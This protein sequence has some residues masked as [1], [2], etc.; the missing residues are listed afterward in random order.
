VTDAAQVL[1]VFD[2]DGTLVDSAR[3]LTD[4]GNALV[5]AYG[6]PPL[7]QAQIVRMVGDGARELV[8]RL[9][10]ACRLDV[11]LD[12]AL[13]RFL[14]EYNDRLVATTRP[15]EGVVELLEQISAVAR[16]V[17]LTNKPEYATKRLLNNLDLERFFAD[18]I[19][20]DTAIARKPDPAGLL[21]LLQRARV[22]PSRALMVGDSVADL[23]TAVAAAVPACLVRYG[24]GFAQV[25]ESERSAAAYEVDR[26]S[27]IATIVGRLAPTST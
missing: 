16:L 18:V 14:H 15:Y 11:P 9:L 23:H 21:S 27:E 2:L 26:P 24:F 20:G 19:A 10:A 17:V 12:E 13:T 6:V 1:I 4:A 25:P 3:D 22:T 8:R 7:P 5:A